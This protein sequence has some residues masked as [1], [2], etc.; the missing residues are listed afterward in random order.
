[1]KQIANHKSHTAFNN[2]KYLVPRQKV[3]L[4]MSELHF[5]PGSTNSMKDYK[6]CFSKPKEVQHVKMN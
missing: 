1:M 5:K 3:S 4:L 6:R 2:S